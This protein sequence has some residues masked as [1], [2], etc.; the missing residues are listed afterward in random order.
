MG[1]KKKGK[2]I[3]QS[4]IFSS[5]AK[6]AKTKHKQDFSTNFFVQR[7]YI[8]FTCHQNKIIQN[9]RSRDNLMLG[10]LLVVCAL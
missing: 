5:F 8:V 7:L 3:K 2:K 4:V 6:R 10:L 9:K 1:L